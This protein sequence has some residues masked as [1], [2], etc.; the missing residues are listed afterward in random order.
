MK[1]LLSLI[2]V[3]AAAADQGRI[4][5][6]SRHEHVS[7]LTVPIDVGGS[8][9]AAAD[10]NA[11]PGLMRSF[12]RQEQVP[13]AVFEIDSRGELMGET[14]RAPPKGDKEKICDT[15]K[16]NSK[17]KPCAWKVGEPCRA[18]LAGSKDPELC[19]KDSSGNEGVD[20]TPWL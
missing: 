12:S 13:P 19:G 5:S 3:V 10:A 16:C 20:C 2:L 8:G 1:C 18:L 9:V 15:N 14:W 7:D 17:T 4:R 11:N 6:T